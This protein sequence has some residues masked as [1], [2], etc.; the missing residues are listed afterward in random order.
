[1]AYRLFNKGTDRIW[2]RS[3]LYYYG[4]DNGLQEH[5]GDRRKYSYGCDG[6]YSNGG[7]VYDN[8][9]RSKQ[10]KD[11]FTSGGRSSSFD[12]NVFHIKLN[13]SYTVEAAIVM[14]IVFLSVATAILYAYRQR[15]K[16]FMKYVSQEAAQDMAHT[17]EIWRPETSNED[18]VRN[19]ANNR[20]KNIGRLSGFEIS[21]SRNEFYETADAD[22]TFDDEIYETKINNIENYM[23]IMAVVMDF[24]KEKEDGENSQ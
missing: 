5:I 13:A 4:L 17:E 16:V 19:R 10:R 15:D 3:V 1:M 20:L 23:R 2:G 7:R 12:S 22:N 11:T 14:S 6:I 18:T 21:V 24:K 9:K 8:G